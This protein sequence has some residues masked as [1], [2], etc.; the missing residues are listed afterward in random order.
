VAREFKIP[1]LGEN[2]ESGDVAKVLVS[3]GDT[4]KEDQP[5][6]ELETDK[7]VVEIP[8]TVSGK[9]KELR[10]KA[11]DQVTIGQVILTLE[12]E[13]EEIEEGT[14]AAETEPKAE[15]ITAPKEK[16]VKGEERR[17]TPKVPSIETRV[18]TSEPETEVAPV[19]EAMTSAPAPATPS[20]R[21][22]ARELGVD[23]HQVQGSGPGGRISMDNVKHYVRSQ[24][25]ERGQ[26]ATPEMALPSIAS[27]LPQFEKWGEVRRE[28]LSQVR[29]KIAEHM[30]HAWTIPHVTQCDNADI[31]KLEQDRKRLAKQVEEAGSKLTLTAIA[32]KVVASAL[33]IF[34]QFNTSLDLAAKELIYKQY[35][36]IGV[37]VDT[38]YGLLVPVI[39]EVNQKNITE[40]AV[41]LT[42]LAEKARSRK[43]SPEE[44]EGS[45]FTITNLGGLGGSHFTPIINWPAVAILGISRA[46]M[47]PLYI[48]GEFQPRLL[49]PL[50][51]SYDHRVIDGADAVRFLRW[52]VEALED[53]IL[54]SLKG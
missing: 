33:K 7:A 35:C 45:T 42:E 3:A 18:E 13:V 4:L 30:T 39:R 32:L 47:S 9:I 38:E 54:L 27:P 43:L 12:E 31:T 23:I 21:R 52:I 29:G 15:E 36:H 8:S 41:E 53:P 1:E 50:S 25:S 16:E 2:I 46:K 6:L 20:V 5:V 19:Q 49:L 37:A 22:L 24:V 40:L 48:E 17:P 11:G 26:T 10:V 14:L 44:M 34:P 28:S 51:L